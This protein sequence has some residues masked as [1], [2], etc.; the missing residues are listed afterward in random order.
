MIYSNKTP[1]W[2]TVI[3]IIFAL[4]LFQFPYLLGLCAADSFERILVWIYPF[5]VVIASYLAYICYDQ[6]P[7]MTCILLIL[8]AMTHAGIWLLVNNTY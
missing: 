8:I 4:P 2:V 7:T 1:I 6:R 5:Y 3:I